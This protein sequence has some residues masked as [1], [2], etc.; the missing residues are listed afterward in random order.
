MTIIDCNKFMNNCEKISFFIF[1]H[2]LAEC[3]LITDISTVVQNDKIIYDMN[4]VCE[5]MNFT[6]SPGCNFYIPN[7]H[8]YISYFDVDGELIY[9]NLL[10]YDLHHNHK[11]LSI[12]A[13]ISFSISST[14]V[15]SVL[16]IAVHTVSA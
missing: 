7:I 14:S 5:D 8:N 3:I 10:S 9:I 12:G 15:K 2:L 4:F 1:E 11:D 13:S 16:T 6:S